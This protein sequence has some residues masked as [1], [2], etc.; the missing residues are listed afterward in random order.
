MRDKTCLMSTSEMKCK[1][2]SLIHVLVNLKNEMQVE[3]FFFNDV[4]SY[5]SS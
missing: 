3:I 4:F 1:F 5:A 2:G